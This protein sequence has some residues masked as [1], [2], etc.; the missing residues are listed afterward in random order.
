MADIT[1][2]NLIKYYG[3][4]LILNDISFDLQ[5]GEKVALLGG[6][7]AGKTTLFHILAGRLPYDGG[8]ASVGEGR[9]VGIIDQIPI[10]RE[11]ASVNSVLRLAFQ[12]EDAL[13]RRQS[14]LAD[15]MAAGDTSEATLSAYGTI[16]ERL[17]WLGGY[18]Y[19]YEIDKV[20]AGLAISKEQRAQEF[21][22]L[23]G[24]EKTRVNLARII[25]ERTDILLLDEP[26]NH[27][28]MDSV[29]WL[30]DY[31]DAYRGTVLTISHDRYFL[32]QC[33]ERIIEL[34]DGK[35]EFYAG[36]YS[37]YADERERRYEQQLARHENEMA[38]VRRL[39]A[40]SRRMHEH[41][42]EHLAKR[43]ASIDKRIQR[44]KVTD[45]PKKAKKMSMSFGDPNYETEEV[46]KVRGIC[47][48]FEGR[49][50]LHDV[51]F[52]I[53][54]RERVAILGDNGTGKTTLLRIL[55]GELEAD[56]GTVKRGVGL[57]PAYLP[58][59]VR[60]ANEHRTLIDTLLYDKNV[61]VQT[62]RNRLG[63][64][65]FSG[66]EQLKTVSTLSGGEKS[67]LRLCELMYDP[68]NLLVLDE[69]TN[70]LD[71]LSREW[72]EEAVEGFTGTLLFVSHDRYFVSRF[73]T[74]IIYLENGTYTDFQGTYDAFLAYREA[75]PPA[76]E[77]PPPSAPRAEK[78]RTKGGGTKNLAK[79]VNAL[80]R[81]IAALEAR[82][83]EIDA[84]MNASASDPDRLCDLIAERE[85]ADTALTGKME[86]WEAAS[87]ALE[88]G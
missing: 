70:H 88:Q 28:D 57:R 5:P 64:F 21:A 39:E 82:L 19:E 68:L 71:L 41:G 29:R 12:E 10:V 15:R 81:E 24:G 47:K 31:L 16:S 72:I 8:T 17:E 55:L 43:A 26:T 65:Q 36:S 79:R 53:R 78:P 66:E 40:V 77:A 11:G 76:E 13:R 84:E 44:M 2:Q 58:Q 67:R 73:A 14:M 45:R 62:A 60:F 4:R 6:N 1:V 20:C 87:A 50:V 23:S 37:F 33:C 18:N 85:E 80:E 63:A 83:A 86:E 48:R 54:N 42:T 35:C 25:L 7:G 52:Q 74:R 69:P 30:G 59:Q 56:S 3:D 75:N 34:R 9:T 38:E 61:T 32:D 46:L 51:T 27:L 49:Q 22:L